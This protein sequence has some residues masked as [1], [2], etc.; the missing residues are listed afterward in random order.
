[1]KKTTLNIKIAYD[2]LGRAEKRIADWIL[3]HEGKILS[4]S[5]VELAEQ[6]NCGEATIVRFAKK[7]GFSGYQELKL[8]LAQE[9]HGTVVNHTYVR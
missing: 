4:L 1:M 7:M 2:R 6:C 5:I 8:S 9:I 3:S